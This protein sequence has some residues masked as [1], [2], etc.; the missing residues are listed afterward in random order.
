M[1]DLLSQ[2][3]LDSLWGPA[4]GDEGK[5]ESGG[6][7]ESSAPAAGLSQADLDALWGEASKDPVPGTAEP[8]AAKPEKDASPPKGENLS[9]D[10]IDK[11]FA[12][13]RR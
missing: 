2:D 11:L 10:D 9:Q 3:D 8:E 6:E 7:G 1:A 12:E 13:F 5:K 4:S